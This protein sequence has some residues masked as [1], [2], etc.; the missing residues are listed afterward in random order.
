MKSI[1]LILCAMFLTIQDKKPLLYDVCRLAD[2]PDHVGFAGSVGGVSNGV[3]IMAGGSN[4]PEGTRPWAG[5]IKKWYKDIYILQTPDG[6]WEKAGTL[7]QNL[8]YAVSV[9]YKDVLVCAGG[10]NE[11]GHSDKVFGLRWNNKTKAIEI[12][13]FADLPFT[14]ANASGEVVDNKLF[15]AGGLQTPESQ[16]ALKTFLM[17]D[18]SKPDSQ[19]EILPSW[20]GVPRMLSVSASYEDRFFL[21]SGT[22]LIAD[23]VSAGTKRKYLND[24]Y[25]Y[26]LK[27]NDWKAL[28]HLEA[29]AV[30]AAG[31]ALVE[32]S[33][34]LILGG[35]S[36]KLA[37]SGASLRDSHPGFGNSV[38]EYTIANDS[39][40]KGQDFPVKIRENVISSPNESD[41]L[42]VTAPLVKWNG[43]YALIG[44]EVRPGTRTPGV[45]FIKMK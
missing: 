25:V 27:T 14:L 15:I 8:G 22:N 11:S 30:A 36:G 28:S 34:I 4:F 13:Y 35:D 5:G 31:P 1:S 23:S 24:A 44:G 3:L 2:V 38:L 9:S 18:L 16:E 33:R 37:E 45:Y 17:L 21:F 12:E 40:S 42:P 32:K 29:P 41:F 43:G 39:W 10:S 7:P 20:P 19:W 26:S 6:S